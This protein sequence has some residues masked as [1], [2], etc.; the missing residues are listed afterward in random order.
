MRN[1]DVNN[2]GPSGAK[3]AKGEDNGTMVKPEMAKLS[4]LAAIEVVI[5]GTR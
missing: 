1:V 2:A 4:S 5:K 3:R